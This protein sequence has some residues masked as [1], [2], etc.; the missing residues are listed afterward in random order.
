M[1]FQLLLAILLSVQRA[2]CSVERDAYCVMPFDHAQG[3]RR[4]PQYT[5]KRRINILRVAYVWRKSLILAPE[6]WFYNLLK[7][8]LIS[9]KSIY[10]S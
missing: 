9:K 6:S 1:Q 4:A 2:A 10:F 8:A 5:S 3:K 7:F